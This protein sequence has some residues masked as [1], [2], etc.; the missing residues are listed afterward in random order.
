MAAPQWSGGKCKTVQKVKAWFRHNDKDRREEGQHTN[1]HIDKSK[2][3]DN[4]TYRGLTY[5]QMCEVF[6]NL[7][8]S[9][10]KGRESSGKNA[11]VLLQTVILYPPKGLT[12]AQEVAWFMDAGKVLEDRYG[13]NLIE[14][15]F[16]M[17]EEHEYID[18]VTKEKVMS[19]NHGH[20]R[21]FPE[22]DGKL[23][24]KAFSSQAEIKA[25][26]HALDVMSVQKYGVPMMDGTGKK[27]KGSV[28]ALKAASLRAEVEL[29]EEQAATIIQDAMEMAR[30]TRTEARRDAKAVKKEADDYAYK[31]RLKANRDAVK[32][33]SKAEEDAEAKRQEAQA[34]KA[35]ATQDAEAVRLQV[36]A[37]R[38]ERD[39]AQA[40]RDEA[41]NERDTAHKEA[42]DYAGK[43]VKL[44]AACDSFQ[45][46]LQ[47]N[48]RAME[49]QE[50]KLGAK[51]LLAALGASMRP[52]EVPAPDV[53]AVVAKGIAAAQERPARP[54]AL[55]AWQK[56]QDM[57]ARDKA[58]TSSGPTPWN[59]PEM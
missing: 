35:Q 38:R 42:L 31:T 3:K 16:D 18:P 15:Q 59:G 7:L 21:L 22:V 45:T 4:F 30:E 48:V 9:V 41:R 46:A 49:A 44:K 34:I 55:T 13:A 52:V 14:I 1:P 20:A 11:R 8:A 19:R 5:K 47:G 24:A 10:D 32:T 6:D 56:L 23:N 51:A 57:A 58:R 12:R 54:D 50:A 28:E 29:L 27:S 40:E 37:A 39:E 43:A 17:D 36:V 53:A 2:T 25:L 26:N 33:V